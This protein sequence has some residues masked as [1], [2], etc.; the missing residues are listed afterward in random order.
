MAK[1]SY[2]NV[3]A[4]NQY[5]RDVVKGKIVVC[6]HVIDACQRHL[7]DLEQ[8]KSKSFKYKFNKDFAEKVC[9][10][11]QL[12]PHTKGEWAIIYILLRIWLGA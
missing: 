10:F 6:K 8:E 5:A 7:N 2:K 3:N 12:L 4:A 11:I 1:K 9:K